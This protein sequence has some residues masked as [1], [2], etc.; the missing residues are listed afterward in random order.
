MV[1]DGSSGLG[2]LALEGTVHSHRT[3]VFPHAV[4]TGC[5]QVP[6]M[7]WCSQF[8]FLPCPGAHETSFR[9]HETS[10]S[11]YLHRLLAGLAS[12]VQTLQTVQTFEYQCILTATGRLCM[13]WGKSL[14]VM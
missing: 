8:C 14:P 11:W 13:R 9:A 3:A 12:S 4:Y 1:G 10:F 2:S 5:T 7:P 6:H